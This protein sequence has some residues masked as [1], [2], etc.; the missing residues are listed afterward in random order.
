M[1]LP[2]TQAAT[3]AA[4]RHRLAEIE[5]A[6][7]PERDRMLLEYASPRTIEI[8]GEELLYDPSFER[9]GGGFTLRP[10]YYRLVEGR[11]VQVP[12]VDAGA[13]ER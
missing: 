10:K 1:T 6:S 5:A 4:H 2:A 3:E 8:Q 7:D 12:T 11:L 9:K 13:A